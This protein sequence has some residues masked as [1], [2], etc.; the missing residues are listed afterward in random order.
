MFVTSIDTSELDKLQKNFPRRHASALGSAVSAESYRLAKV[1]K[2]FARSRGEGTWPPESPL[3]KAMRSRK[4]STGRRYPQMMSYYTRYDVNKKVPRSRIGILE[5]GPRA[6][7]KGVVSVAK[8]HARGYTFEMTRRG[9]RAIAKQLELKY[10]W[11]R[12]R[13]RSG[14]W[15]ASG[16]EKRRSKRINVLIP[17]LGMHRVPARPVAAAVLKK[18]RHRI[19][20]NIARLYATKL[21]G[22]RWDRSWAGDWGSG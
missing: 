19:G 4:Y 1:Q 5:E 3:T 13:G 21:T 12:E 7:P 11:S 8:K 14:A 18:E 15:L 16:S 10:G 2:S 9:Q 22:G 6:A 20:R 17:K